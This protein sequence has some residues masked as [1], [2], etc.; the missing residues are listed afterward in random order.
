MQHIVLRNL[1]NSEALPFSDIKGDE[2]VQI[3]DAISGSCRQNDALRSKIPAISFMTK[4]RD[5]NSPLCQC[6]RDRPI[7]NNPSDGGSDNE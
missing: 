3:Q 4:K 7:N 5:E 2:P 1:A 6:Y